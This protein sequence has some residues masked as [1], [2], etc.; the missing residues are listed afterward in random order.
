MQPA[1]M[2]ILGDG[3]IDS[4]SVSLRARN[5]DQV[6]GVPLETFVADLRKEI[7]DKVTQ[8]SLVVPNDE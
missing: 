8:P 5:G 2:V 1:Y 7:L 3:E 6:S 4:R